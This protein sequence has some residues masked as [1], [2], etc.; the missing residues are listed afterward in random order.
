MVRW[1][2]EEDAAVCAAPYSV[3][4]GW[5]GWPAVIHTVRLRSSMQLAACAWPSPSAGWYSDDV[6]GSLQG[7]GE[8]SSEFGIGVDLGCGLPFAH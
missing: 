1:R 8:L 2:V 3:A 4:L 7:L 6:A 5:P